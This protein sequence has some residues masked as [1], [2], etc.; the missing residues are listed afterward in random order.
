M[1]SVSKLVP[2]VRE[3]AH[4]EPVSGVG[5]P[6][7]RFVAASVG[8]LLGLLLLAML[9]L[10]FGAVTLSPAEVVS[11]LFSD[12]DSFARTVVWE[13]RLPR[14]LDAIIVGASL[15]VAGTLLQVVTRNPLADPTIMGVTA[16]AGLATSLTLL[17]WPGTGQAGLAVGGVVGGLVGAGIVAAIAWG[18]AVSP[19]RLTLAGVAVAAFFGSLI[20]GILASSRAF[21]QV[22]L[23]FLAGGMYGSDWSDLRGLA[24]VAIPGFVAAL[25][26]ADRLNVLVL[27]DELALGLGVVADRTRLVAL[28]LVGVLTGAAVAVAGLVSFVG[29]VSPHLARFAVRNDHRYLLPMAALVGALLVTAADLLGRLLISPAELPMGIVTAAVGA[30]FLLYLLRSRA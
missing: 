4:Y 3:N 21:I 12:S 9:S 22:S 8:A 5:L 26:L 16:A 15:A 14:L 24:V 23:G 28:A 13:I 18:G 27:G 2:E 6:P 30:P 19:L 1:T 20:V 25:Y 7:R 29:L 10:M 17:A 11:G